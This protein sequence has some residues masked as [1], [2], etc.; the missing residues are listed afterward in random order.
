MASRKNG[1]SGVPPVSE[2]TVRVA[3]SGIKERSDVEDL[4]ALGADA[5]LI[6]SALLNAPDAGAKLKELT[7]A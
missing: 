3:E 4:L 6:G 7:D 2:V 1:N 5:F